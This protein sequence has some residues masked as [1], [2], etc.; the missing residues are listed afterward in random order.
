MVP[1]APLSVRIRFFNRSYWP[2][3]GATGQLLTELA[4]DLVSKHG[5]DVSVVAGPPL[6]ADRPRPGWRLVG[7]EW[8]NGVEILRCRGTTHSVRRF[9]SRAANYLTYFATACLAGRRSPR[10]DIVVALTDP[11]IIGLAA[12]W[13]ARRSRARFVFLCEDVFPEVARLVEDFQSEAVNDALQ[14]TSRFIVKRADRVIALGD[15]MRDRLVVGKGADPAKVAVIHNWSDCAAIY[16]GEKRNPFSRTHGLAEPFVVMHSGNVGLSQN[17]DALLD[18]AARLRGHRDIVFAIVGDGASRAALEARARAEGLGSVRFLP[19]QPRVRLAESY[20]SADVFV[21][22][23]KPGLAGCIV[24]SKLYGILA[25]GRPYV[26]AV[27]EPSEVAAITK[28]YDCG[29]LV[30]PDDPEALAAAIL[31][32]HGDRALA[33][34]LGANARRAALDFDRP[35]QVAKYSRLL[36]ALVADA[37]RPDPALKRLFDLALSG[38]GLV[39]SLPLWGLIGLLIKLDDGGPVFYGQERVGRGGRRFKS[40]KFRSM[41]PDSDRRFG[42]LQAAEDDARITRVGRLLRA[43]AMDELPQLWNIF[44]GD[45]SFVGPRALAPAEIEVEGSREAVALEKVPGYEARH[46]VRPGLTGIAQI[47]AR[48]DLPRRQKFRL[49]VL[50][51]RKQSF[52]LDLRLIALSFW[53]SFRGKWEARGR[54]V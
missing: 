24:P 40:W 16:P 32:L 30:P 43:T 39:G 15:T 2:D 42:P 45:M 31:R 13:A 18:A 27:E 8:H 12:L 54:K 34:R 28:S 5:C 7:R 1:S 41:V 49:D 10:P 52:W 29:L 48:R 37:P 47:Y 19:Y 17:L 26:A 22:S 46:R 11:P 38:L 25:A 50:Y 36:Q 53:I 14:R 9:S 20:A 33:R 35:L 51:I 23:L 3:F 44:A 21:V 6:G 4:E